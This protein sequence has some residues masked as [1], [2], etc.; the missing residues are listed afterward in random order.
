MRFRNDDHPRSIPDLGITVGP[1]EEYEWPGWVRSIH[2]HPPTGSVLLDPEP[3]EG[4]DPPKARNGAGGGKPKGGKADTNGAEGDPPA[5]NP[6]NPAD[7]AAT[8]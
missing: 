6:P 1:F 4:D 8:A 7:P 5:S 2:G 3:E